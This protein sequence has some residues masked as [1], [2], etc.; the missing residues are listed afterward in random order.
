MSEVFFIRHGQASYGSDNYD[1][2]SALGH[3]QAKWLGEYFA[4][5]QQTFDAIIMGDMV[6]HRETAEGICQG[7][8]LSN[9]SIDV[10]PSLN[11]FD[12]QTLTQAYLTS[13]GESLPPPGTPVPEFYRIL[14]KALISWASGEL[15][16]GTPETWDNFEQR[17]Q[18]NLRLIQDRPPKQKVL[19]VSSGGAISMALRFILNAPPE[20]MVNLNLQTRNTGISH[21]FF[22]NSGFSLNGF[23]HTPHLDSPERLDSVTYS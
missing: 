3:Q 18:Q 22:N 7:M 16:D 20:T 1:Q 23:N 9:P 14:K 10:H 11:E 17:T 8:D 13:R 6:R 5:R 21:C 15:T 2:L 12:F 19:V 4:N